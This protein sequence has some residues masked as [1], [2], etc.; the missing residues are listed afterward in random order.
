MIIGNLISTFAGFIILWFS[1]DIAHPLLGDRPIEHVV[2]TNYVFWLIAF[3]VSILIELPFVAK[4]ISQR[5]FHWQTLAST[6]GVNVV[7]YAGLLVICHFL[8]GLTVGTS[9][10]V[11]P[12]SK[13]RD[14]NPGW[15]YYLSDQNKVMRIRLDGAQMEATKY[16]VAGSDFSLSIDSV[17]P[18]SCDLVAFKGRDASTLQAKIGKARQ[19]AYLTFQYDDTPPDYAARLRGSHGYYPGRSFEEFW[20]QRTTDHHFVSTNLFWPELGM[21]FRDRWND[22]SFSISCGTPFIRWTWNFATTLPDGRVVA[23]LGPQIVVVDIPTRKIAWLCRGRSPTV[24]LDVPYI[25]P[26]PE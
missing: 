13:I 3:I 19:S 15:V 10:Q 1:V 6:C 25:A 5:L 22:S 12:L 18:P 20:G 17:K 7:T 24:L 14:K 4:A 8:Q 23:E 9:A 16:T 11:V 21:N 2:F 26:D